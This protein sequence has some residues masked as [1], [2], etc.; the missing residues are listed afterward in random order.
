M[1]RMYA[2][3]LCILLIA[4]LAVTAFAAEDT[5]ITVTPSATTVYRGDAVTVTVSISSSDQLS[6]LGYLPN[7]NSDYFSVAP[8]S[9]RKNVLDAV[10]MPGDPQLLGITR[11]DFTVG[12]WLDYDAEPDENGDYPTKSV[13]LN[14]DLLYYDLIIKEDAPFGDFTVT[15]RVAINDGD[16]LVPFELIDATI[17][18]A[19]KHEYGKGV[20]DGDKHIKTCSICGDVQT[21]D[22]VWDAGKVTTEPT[23]KDKGVKTF[24]CADCKATKTEDVAKTTDHKY[25]AWTANGDKHERT[26]S[27]CSKIECEDHGWDTGKVTTEPTCKDEGVKT[28][29]CEDCNATKLESITRTDDHTYGDCTK[30]SEE[31]HTHT[32]AVC[33]KVEELPHD[34]EEGR[35]IDCGAYQFWRYI[36]EGGKV[37]ITKYVGP[38]G[39]VEILEK[40]EDLDVVEIA[41]NAFE[42]CADIT[43]ISIPRTVRRIAKAFVGCTALKKVSIFDMD[44]WMAME[45][46]N[47]DCNPLKTAGSLYL[48]GEL[49]TEVKI[50]G[51]VAGHVFAGS[52]EIKSVII[53]EDVEQIG[54]GAFDGCEGI[55]NVYCQG[56]SQ[57]MEN[58]GIKE[59]ESLAAADVYCDVG[60]GDAGN[61]D[62]DGEVSDGDALYLLRFTLFPERYPVQAPPDMN[63]DG[64]AD[65]SDALYLLRYTLF[66]ERY[67]LYPGSMLS[68]IYNKD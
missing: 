68:E 39:D 54:E 9:K 64:V 5:K 37:I 31:E 32:C 20:E 35:C 25:G 65:D 13:I 8:V 22:H 7:S 21:A 46:A 48:N 15:D 28:Y 12:S 16:K 43:G 62:G 45:F 53:A 36:I 14:G 1:K 18:V 66:A 40:I 19:C 24:T 58:L 27:V 6:A 23:C 50:S 52:T 11:T 42:G 59:N 44:A 41:E 63:N 57:Q 60:K 47:A 67:P 33:G 4:A 2:V 30:V 49:V 38:G 56:D 10:Y 55:S 26:C 51:T 17:T 3:F 61:I 29:I 34:Y